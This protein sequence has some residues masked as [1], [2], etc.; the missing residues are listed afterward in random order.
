MR[1]K[2]QKKRILVLKVVDKHAI[3]EEGVKPQLQREVEVHTRL[4]HPNIL[5]MYAYFTDESSG[6]L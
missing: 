3:L 5:R 6:E 1:V 2:Q 4:V